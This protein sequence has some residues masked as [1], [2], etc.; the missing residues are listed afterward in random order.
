MDV[1]YFKENYAVV[2]ATLKSSKNLNVNFVNN[3]YNELDF[4]NPNDSI[5]LPKNYQEIQMSILSKKLS[6]KALVIKRIL[7]FLIIYPIKI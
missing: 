6:L 3:F 5:F 4:D 2:R 1:V 7:L